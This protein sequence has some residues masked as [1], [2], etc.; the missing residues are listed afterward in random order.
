MKLIILRDDNSSAKTF[1]SS[2][3]K[4]RVFFISL[5][6]L[7]L[8]IGAS[9][10]WISF[11]SDRYEFEEN[12][13]ISW[14][15]YLTDHEKEFTKIK[16]KIN[17]ELKAILNKSAEL[18]SRII[19]LDAL[20]E[21]I[22]LNS[23][24]E[25]G[26][27]DFRINPGLGGAIFEDNRNDSLVSRN[28]NILSDLLNDLSNQVKKSEQQLD[29]LDQQ[30]VFKDLNINSF[31]AGKPVLSGWMSSK[32]G[33]RIDPFTGKPAWHNGVDFAGKFGDGIV[34]VASGVVT[35]SGKKTGYGNLIEINHGNGY[36][37][38]YA[39]NQSHKVFSGDIVEKG[40]IIAEMGSSGRSTGPHVHF[41]V[42]RNNKPMNPERYIYR[43]GL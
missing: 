27:F 24:L 16:I 30:L 38:R 31:V 43:S 20:G 32:F 29:I 36:I 41:E 21:K 5:I 14:Q 23:K 11:I 40:Q 33:R 15:R 10:A 9:L 3:V 12:K 25:N 35:F 37:T 13:F 26:E 34:A 2:N 28:E 19:R 17:N 39:H 18:H 22:A 4:H 42:L 1:D 6:I 8:S 7:I